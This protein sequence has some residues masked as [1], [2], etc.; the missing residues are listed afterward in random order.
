MKNEQRRRLMSILLKAF[1]VMAGFTGLILIFSGSDSFVTSAKAISYFTIQSNL[2]ILV[3]M[4]LALYGSIRAYQGRK[5][6]IPRWFSIL[7]YVLTVSIALTFTVFAVLLS[8]FMP[9]GYLASPSN[10]C[11]HFLAPLAAMADFIFLDANVKLTKKELLWT[12]VPPLYYLVFALGLSF[13]GVKFAGD[14]SVPYYFLDYT[15]RGWLTISS[16]GIGVVYWIILMLGLVISLAIGLRKLA[17]GVQTKRLKAES[18]KN[19]LK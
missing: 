10:I 13:A 19:V 9:L 2:W 12:F 14:A 17:N 6:P 15:T 18:T 16:A 4:S 3:V 8:P 7:K 1:G 5:L 11:M